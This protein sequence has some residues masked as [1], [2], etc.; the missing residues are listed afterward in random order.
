MES[1]RKKPALGAVQTHD[2]LV[3]RQ[4]STN[5]ATTATQCLTTLPIMDQVM[6]V[7][8]SWDSLQH[9]MQCRNGKSL[10]LNAQEESERTTGS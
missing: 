5:C 7:C 4:S 9:L 2:L 8:H 3:C 1:T 10:E 6:F